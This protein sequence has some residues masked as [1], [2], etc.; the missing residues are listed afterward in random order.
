MDTHFKKVVPDTRVFRKLV[1]PSREEVR[2]I[3]HIINGMIPMRLVTTLGLWPEYVGLSRPPLR[4]PNG[5]T[6]FS[7][8]TSIE[9]LND[10]LSRTMG[11]LIESYRADP[12]LVPEFLERKVDEFMAQR[13]SKNIQDAWELANAI[14]FFKGQ[15]FNGDEFS[16]KAI[17][18]QLAMDYAV[19]EVFHLVRYF[20]A[21]L[22][23]TMGVFVRQL[24]ETLK[25]YMH[26]P[27]FRLVDSI[28]EFT[29][30]VHHQFPDE[31]NLGAKKIIRKAR[32]GIKPLRLKEVGDCMYLW[33]S[34]QGVLGTKGLDATTVI[35]FDTQSRKRL[36]LLVDTLAAELGGTRLL[37]VLNESGH[38]RPG[39][40]LVLCDKTC[41]LKD[42]VN[43]EE[44][45]WDKLKTRCATAP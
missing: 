38:L 7:N 16:W 14:V 12:S 42:E 1:K 19:D 31:R 28:V 8:I 37:A 34:V 20:P 39:R 43:V 17:S 36:G 29:W 25:E 23:D 18:K 27:V 45:I 3:L 30:N 6:S 10:A 13:V 5:L 2:G 44:I 26:L 11:S 15:D 4:N 33:I 40:I 22:V 24:T 9:T 32:E 41:V 35:T 21:S